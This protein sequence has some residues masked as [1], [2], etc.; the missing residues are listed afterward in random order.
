MSPAPK[1]E[2]STA[3]HSSSWFVRRLQPELQRLGHRYLL[4]LAHARGRVSESMTEVIDSAHRRATQS[5]LALELIDDF[6]DGTYRHASWL[7]VAA[8]AGALLHR[9]EPTEVLPKYVPVRTGGL[10]DDDAL[11]AVALRIA[12]QDLMSYCK[13]KGYS[14]SDVFA[15]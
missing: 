4:R 3:E 8:L 2:M 15:L 1:E 10:L 6:K 14:V 7:S 12:R 11:L 13:H 5:R 9:V